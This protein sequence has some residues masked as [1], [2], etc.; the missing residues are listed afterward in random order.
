MSKPTPER[1]RQARFTIAS[2]VDLASNDNFYVGRARDLSIGG[3][4]VETVASLP[5]GARL[6]VHLRIHGEVF[7]I[8]AEVAWS[9][10]P[11]GDAP[12]GL[13]LRF[14]DL[15][16][17][18]QKAIEGFMTLRPPLVAFDPGPPSAAPP[19]RQPSLEPEPPRPP[20]SLKPE[21]PRRGP[22]PLPKGPPPL[23]LR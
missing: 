13:G 14:L 2:D 22:P 11:E 12:G 8:D 9:L 20:L 17:N 7:S 23:P 15:P 3:L 5:R 16:V 21:P 18:A 19:S 6:A 1:R 10:V 4:Y